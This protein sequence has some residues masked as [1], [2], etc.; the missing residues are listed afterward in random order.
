MYTIKVKTSTLYQKTP[1]TRN[2]LIQMIIMD[3]STCRNGLIFLVLTTGTELL[4][5]SVCIQFEF[6]KTVLDNKFLL[7]I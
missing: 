5:K 1:K 3:K 2:D 7:K 6:V 4:P